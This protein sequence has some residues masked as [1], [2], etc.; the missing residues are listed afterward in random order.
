MSENSANIFRIS[1]ERLETKQRGVYEFGGNG[2]CKYLNL[3]VNRLCENLQV[4][5]FEGKAFII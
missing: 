1:Y 4:L 2:I 5:E 3:A